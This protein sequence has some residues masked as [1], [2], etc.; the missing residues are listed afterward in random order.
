MSKYLRLG[1]HLSWI[2][3]LLISF[4]FI[5]EIISENY[6]SAVTLGMINKPTWLSAPYGQQYEILNREV[7]LSRYMARAFTNIF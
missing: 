1:F 3:V 2:S 7:M 5:T 4:G 6:R